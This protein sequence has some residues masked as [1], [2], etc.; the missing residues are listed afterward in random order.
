MALG[1][2]MQAMAALDARVRHAGR[3]H[4]SLTSVSLTSTSNATLL[5]APDSA[6]LILFAIWV[7][8]RNAANVNLI[9]TN[10]SGTQIAPQLGPFL[11]DYHDIIELPPTEVEGDVNITPSAA[12]AASNDVLVKAYAVAIG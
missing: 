11:T 5:T 12:A 3:L 6:T 8:N 2:L 4:T 1:D 10:S 9:L 7:Y